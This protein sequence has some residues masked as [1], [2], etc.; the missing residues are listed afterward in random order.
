[1]SPA[2]VAPVVMISVLAPLAAGMVV[3]WVAPALGERIAKPISMVA[4]VLLAA[5]VI[6]VL[7]TAMPMALSLIGNGTLVAMAVF[8][9]A[10]YAVGH[11]LGGPEPE[12]RA[13]LALCTASRHPGLAMA[14]AHATFPGQKQVFGAVLLYILV[15]IIV[16]ALYRAW[17]RRHTS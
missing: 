10:G 13:V 8:L 6:P 17:R 3:R 4:T 5:A 15:N 2:E 7:I 14:I 9:L 1:M 12:D 11:L 16:W